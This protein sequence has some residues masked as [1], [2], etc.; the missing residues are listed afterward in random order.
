MAV[1]TVGIY[2]LA[3]AGCRAALDSVRRQGLH[4]VPLSQARAHQ[5]SDFHA[6]LDSRVFYVI[7][8]IS[9][10]LSL[11]VDMVTKSYY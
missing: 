1:D 6:V 8:G 9:R 5:P 3:S 11:T 10:S 7:K 2:Y 4:A